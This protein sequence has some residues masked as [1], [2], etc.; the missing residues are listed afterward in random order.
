MRRTGSPCG[1][2][3]GVIRYT[4]TLPHCWGLLVAAIYYV[5]MALLIMPCSTYPRGV[6]LAAADSNLSHDL[7]RQAL[8]GLVNLSSSGNADANHESMWEVLLLLI[9]PSTHPRILYPHPS[10][11]N[12]C[13]D[14]HGAR[15]VMLR[16]AAARAPE[17]QEARMLA[18]WALCNLALRD[19]SRQSMWE[20]AETRDALLGCIAESEPQILR[21]QALRALTSL[22]ADETNRASM[23]SA[24]WQARAHC[25]HNATSRTQ[26][27][28][29][30]HTH[31]AE[32]QGDGLLRPLVTTARKSSISCPLRKPA[33]QVLVQLQI[34]EDEIGRG[35]PAELRSAEVVLADNERSNS[36]RRSSMME[37][38]R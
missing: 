25:T 26:P 36:R 35:A 12:P 16:C 28:T 30:P 21:V 2:C 33:Q 8:W 3:A 32:P 15:R 9:F 5:T 14:A 37:Q 34:S 38:V 29:Q 20:D 1:P 6:L 23:L 4:Q 24:L 10:T 17:D 31:T 11:L 7:R 19:A 27:R 13:Q 18:V 22:A